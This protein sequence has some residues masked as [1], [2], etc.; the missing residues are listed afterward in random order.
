M[1]KTLFTLFAGS[2]LLIAGHASA[3]NISFD[4]LTLAPESHFFPEI[5]T[6][7]TSGSA[8]FN[9]DYDDYSEFGLPGCCHS[10]WVYSNHTDTVTPGHLNQHS[11]FTGVGADGSSNYAIAYFGSPLITFD[12]AVQVSSAAFTNTTYAALSML[13]GDGFAKKFG[14]TSGNDADWFKLTVTGWNDS[15]QTG[16]VDV[17]LADFRFADNSQDYILDS[18]TQFDLSSL[19]TVTSLRFAIDSSDS[20]AWGI[21][22]PAYFAMDT[23][24]VTAVP[25][26]GQAALLLAGLALIGSAARRRLS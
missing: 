15:V 6:T 22:T 1:N 12:T 16:S 18:W 19:G 14:G 24:N 2:V 20:G 13:N 3:A 7:F 25:E 17:Y 5:T 9:F 11:A 10:G 8:T 4:D 21:N 26:P 23:L